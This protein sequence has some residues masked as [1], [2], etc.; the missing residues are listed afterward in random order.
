MKIYTAITAFSTLLLL[1]PSVNALDLKSNSSNTS[2][3]EYSLKTSKGTRKFLK[4]DYNEISQPIQFPIT[5]VQK[6]ALG[7]RGSRFD[8][9]TLPP[10]GSG[11]TKVNKPLKSR[12]TRKHDSC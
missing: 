4:T 2:L 7:S 8:T 9:N 1:C 12:G 10:T 3:S 6:S 11:S 5:N